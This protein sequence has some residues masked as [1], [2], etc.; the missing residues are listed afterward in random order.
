[1]QNNFVSI[2]YKPCCNATVRVR[3]IDSVHPPG[4]LAVV[5]LTQIV[6]SLDVNRSVGIIAACVE[7]DTMLLAHTLEDIPD[8]F[9]GI[10]LHTANIYPTGQTASR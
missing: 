3:S 1:M 2:L 8:G 5:E 9:G 10:R 4:V 7:G 6:D